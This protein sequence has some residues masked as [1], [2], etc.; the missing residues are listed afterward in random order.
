M[1]LTPNLK[2]EHLK[3]YSSSHKGKTHSPRF[4]CANPEKDNPD[5]K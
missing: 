5:L 3:Y 1:F 4:H 2:R